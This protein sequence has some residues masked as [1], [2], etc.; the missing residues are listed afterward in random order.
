MGSHHEE[1]GPQLEPE[2]FLSTLVHDKLKH[3]NSMRLSTG[4][5]PSF[6]H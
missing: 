6:V 3:A 2:P 5:L 1:E 4:Y